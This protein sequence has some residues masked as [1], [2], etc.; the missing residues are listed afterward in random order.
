MGYNEKVFRYN[1]NG[2]PKVYKVHSGATYGTVVELASD[3][4]LTSLSR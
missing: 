4:D 2:R 3:G 1:F